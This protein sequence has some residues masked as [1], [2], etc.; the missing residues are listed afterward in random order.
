LKEL[1]SMTEVQDHVEV[2]VSNVSTILDAQYKKK[3][4]C[5]SYSL[6]A[7]KLVSPARKTAF[8]LGMP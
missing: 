2:G 6:H 7:V 5:G 1:L 3:N 4:L 8:E